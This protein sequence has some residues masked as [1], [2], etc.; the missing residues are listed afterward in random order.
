L[1]Y[2]IFSASYLLWLSKDCPSPSIFFAKRFAN[3]IQIQEAR[4]GDLRAFFIA[5]D[6]VH[7]G[8]SGDGYRFRNLT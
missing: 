1:F 2:L 4:S 6:T 8:S 3:F 7:G 5:G